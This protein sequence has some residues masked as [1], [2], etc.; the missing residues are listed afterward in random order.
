MEGNVVIFDR[1]NKRV[2]FAA[3]NQTDP[4]TGRPCGMYANLDVSIPSCLHELSQLC[5]VLTAS[6]FPLPVR[7]M[8]VNL[9]SRQMNLEKC[10]GQFS[11][12]SLVLI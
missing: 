5:P 10:V 1:G 9:A 7:E 3:S 11:Y 8:K 2:G 12:S 6:N 4:E